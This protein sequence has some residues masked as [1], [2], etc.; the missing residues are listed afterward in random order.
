[1]ANLAPGPPAQ[2]Q[3]KAAAAERTEEPDTYWGDERAWRVWLA[4]CILMWIV[5]LSSL[6]A[7][8]WGR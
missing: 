5:G 1:M 2:I 8:L 7:G 6:L 4:G 3:A